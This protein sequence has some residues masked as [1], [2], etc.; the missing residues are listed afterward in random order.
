MSSSSRLP[1]TVPREA[2]SRPAVD[3][4]GASPPRVLIEAVDDPT[5]IFIN[6]SRSLRFSFIFR[7]TIQVFH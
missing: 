3:D 7:K 2:S 1:R 5:N 6:M 4:P